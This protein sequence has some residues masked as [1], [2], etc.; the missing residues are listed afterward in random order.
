VS[1]EGHVGGSKNAPLMSV[2]HAG[3]ALA[4]VLSSQLMITLDASV[5]NIALPEIKDTLGFSSA[6]LSW[7]INAYALAF[8]GLLLLGARTGDI[9]G[10]RRV[11]IA[12]IVVFTVASLLGGFAQ[13]PAELLVA[14]GTQGVGAAFASPA[15]LA[16]LTTMY[17]EGRERN[18]ALGYYTAVVIGGAAVGLVA[19]GVLTE[20]ASWR[21]TLFVNVPIGIVVIVIGLVCL[22]T[23]EEEHGQFDLLG[24]ITSTIGMTA[25]VYGFV[26]AASAGWTDPVTIGA[27]A[28]GVALLTLFVLIER[29]AAQPIT[30]L[31]LFADR[32]R[33]ST[34]IARLLLVA[35]MFGTFFFLSQYLQLVLHYSPIRS[36]MAFLPITIVLFAVSQLTSR[37]LVDYLGARFLLVAGTGLSAVGMIL[38]TQ[39]SAD[40]TYVYLATA[41][42][43]FGVG[44]GLLFVPLTTAS[45]DG[46]HDDDAG[47]ASGLVNVTQ[48]LG[49]S[50]GLAVL[51]TVYSA[52]YRHAT[53]A[54]KPGVSASERAIHG[55]VS[56]ADLAFYVATGFILGTLVLVAFVVKAVLPDDESTDDPGGGPEPAAEVSATASH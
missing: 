53:A 6:A 10:R 49:G 19:G 16:V 51:V 1:F 14:R 42:M 34:H 35:G 44:N 32:S 55:F 38:L 5:V 47:A 18:R 40:T 7:V 2:K 12:G 50:L 48:Q 54:A 8:G 15:A 9:L 24:A 46:V 17:A 56:G 33:A 25:L 43:F 29:R 31:R 37:L 3:I 4:V 11:F 52:G 13:S 41:L 27:F 26:R 21:W 20:W 22:P 36:G 45:L 23:G 39:L 30:P 28:I